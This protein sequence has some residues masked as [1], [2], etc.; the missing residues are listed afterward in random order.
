MRSWGGMKLSWILSLLFLA[1][2]GLAQGPPLPRYEVKR[3]KFR[4][5]VDGKLDDRAWQ[6]LQAI[7][8]VF[9]WPGQ[10]GKKQ[11]TRVRLLWDEEFLYAGYDC[12]D[13]DI[14]AQHTERDAPT[15]RDDAVELFLNP[16]P[17]QV[18]AYFGMEMN[19]RA[20]MYDYVR[21]PEAGG[22]KGFDM[23]AFRLATFLRGTMNARGDQDDGWSLE[24]ALPWA[25][26]EGLA[27]PPKSGTE[28][29]AQINRWDGTEPARA[30]S[31]WSD[32]LIKTP[33]PHV[34]QRFGTL[35]FVE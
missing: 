27:P 17:N 1:I 4:I 34:P 21:V 11:K 15:Y 31:M 12:E 35:V 25:N 23:K 20:V 6:D 10:S 7:E 29:R 18:A 33:S 19:A 3:A 9:P 13:E 30:L 32:P 16:K 24:L 28:W 8:L 26:F 2:P 14:T 5:N 22:F